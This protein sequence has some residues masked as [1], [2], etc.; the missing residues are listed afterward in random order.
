MEIRNLVTFLTVAE[1]KNFTRAA[2]KLGYS[3]SAVTVQIKQLERELGVTL[4]DRIGKTVSLTSYGNAFIEYAGAAVEAVD[5]AAAFGTTHDNHVGEIKFGVVGTILSAVLIDVIREY[6]KSYPNVTISVFEGSS[7]ELEKKIRRG[8]LDLA[9]FLDYKTPSNEWV[10]V[11]EER[12]D[13]IA[14]THPDNPIAARGEVTFRELEGER[15][16]LLPKG[17]NYR[18]LFDN[19]LVKNEMSVKPALELVNTD[20]IMR[21]L[22]KE[23]YVSFLPE[24]SVRKYLTS[25]KLAKIN[26]T[27]IDMYQYSQLAYLKGKIIPPHI[28]LFIDTILELC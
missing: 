10:R 21:L 6:Q 3:Q 15:F 23:P 26:V 9:Y 4:F 8:E 1:L 12:E 5:R 19:E 16:I 24:F 17:E 28:Q 7:P 13:I 2:E 18:A 14:V 11:R 22:M 20:M 25:G 27:D